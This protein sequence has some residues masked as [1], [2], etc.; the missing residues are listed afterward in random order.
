LIAVADV[1]RVETDLVNT[2][3]DRFKGALEMKMDVCD[4]R[5][6][7]LRQ[8]LLECVGVFSLGDG[9]ADDIRPGRREL[10]DFGDTLVDIVRIAGGHGL[11]RNRGVAADLDSADPVVADHH[12]ACFRAG[13]HL[14]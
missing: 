11:D 10:V 4:D 8:D 13:D 7:H 5:D 6:T 1:A 12:L 2:G 14:L 9:D 3:F